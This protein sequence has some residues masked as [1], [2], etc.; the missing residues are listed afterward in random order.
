M[1]EISEYNMTIQKTTKNGTTVT[2]Q[3]CVY[4]KTQESYQSKILQTKII[5]PEATY[6]FGPSIS[7]NL[8]PKKS[9]DG[10]ISKKPVVAPSKKVFT[11]PSAKHTTAISS[12]LENN[13]SKKD[14]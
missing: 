13:G 1:T 7:S 11:K 10:L 14:S 5:D 4:K 12:S 6:L 3:E 9:L 8:R 2:N